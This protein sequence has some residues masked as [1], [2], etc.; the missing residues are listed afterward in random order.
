MVLA[1]GSQSD[2]MQYMEI[3]TNSTSAFLRH[4]GRANAAFCDGSVRSG[5]AF[6]YIQTYKFPWVYNAAGAKVQ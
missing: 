4:G 1:D 6:E 5:G 3:G 2:G